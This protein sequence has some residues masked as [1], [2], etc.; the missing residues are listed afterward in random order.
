M[1]GWLIYTSPEV[2][3]DKV[4]L[5]MIATAIRVSGGT[6]PFGLMAHNDAEKARLIELLKGKHGGKA[7]EV[8]TAAELEAAHRKAVNA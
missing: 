1:N 7:I 5:D 4:L 3:T 6:C 2:R 8:L